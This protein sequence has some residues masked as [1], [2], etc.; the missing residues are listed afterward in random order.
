MMSLLQ[1]EGKMFHGVDDLLWATGLHLRWEW[2][3]LVQVWVLWRWEAREMR[4]HICLWDSQYTFCYCILNTFNWRWCI[5]FFVK[6]L[7]VKEEEIG[8]GVFGFLCIEAMRLE[9][10]KQQLE[11]IIPARPETAILWFHS[12]WW[13]LRFQKLQKEP[14]TGFIAGLWQ[15][16]TTEHNFLWSK[17]DVNKL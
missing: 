17:E 16:D 10:A 14:I 12:I 15:A 5:F 4:I 8:F 9:I 13:S 6:V 3:S 2:K 1:W 11:L 7:R